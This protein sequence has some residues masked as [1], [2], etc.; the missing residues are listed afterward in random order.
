M[1]RAVS[2]LSMV[3]AF[4]GTSAS[5]VACGGGTISVLHARG[6]STGEGPARLDILNSSG[7][8]IHRLYIA[9]TSAVDAARLNGVQ[10]GSGE[11]D[12]V[13]GKDRL[14]NEGLVAGSKFGD[15]EI[16]ADRYDVLVTDVDNREQLVKG[17]KLKP[18]AKYVLEIGT[19][20]TQ[21]RR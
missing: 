11:D 20:W 15:M 5:L 19:D 1:L 2:A 10:P 3:V 16:A 7:I 14:G 6:H 13:W 18:G 21:A 17:L 8:G 9:K 4:A 12:A